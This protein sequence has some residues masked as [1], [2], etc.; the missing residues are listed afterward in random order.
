[1]G[2]K[3]INRVQGLNSE[4]IKNMKRPKYFEISVT[5]CTCDIG[6][7]QQFAGEL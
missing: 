7:S 2:G 1:M 6:F 3:N 5:Q 4:N